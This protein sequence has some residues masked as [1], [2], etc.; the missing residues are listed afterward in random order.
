MPLDSELTD[1]QIVWGMCEMKSATEEIY[2][3]QKPWVVYYNQMW[4]TGELVEKT[5]MKEVKQFV[6]EERAARIFVKDHLKIGDLVRIEVEFVDAFMDDF[7][8]SG[9]K[10]VPPSAA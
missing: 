9:Y 4:E 7:Y 2:K 3:G 10:Y 1:D 5:E 8:V 6:V